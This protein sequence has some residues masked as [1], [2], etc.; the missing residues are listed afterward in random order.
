[1]SQHGS[2][3]EMRLNRAF[4][5]FPIPV[6]GRVRC[7][8]HRWCNVEKFGGVVEC[9]DCKVVLCTAC[10]KLFHTCDDM[11]AKKKQLIKQ[12]HQEKEESKKK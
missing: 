1:M 2:Y 7:G 5:H 9:E 6:G 3:G 12:F 11:L 8:L 4:T 10:Y